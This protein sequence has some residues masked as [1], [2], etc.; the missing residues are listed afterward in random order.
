M[1]RP[2]KLKIQE[3]QAELKK[4]LGKQKTAQGKERV[5]AL[6]LL[7]CEHVTTVTDLAVYMG[8][9]RVTVQKW[10]ALYRRGG[11]T[12]LLEYKPPSGRTPSIPQWAVEALKK[13]LAQPEGFGSYHAVQQWLD[14]TL[15]VTASYAAVYRLV[16]GKLKAKLKV[17]KRQSPEQDPE[18]LHRFKTDLGSELSLLK[19]FV[20]ERSGQADVTIRFWCQDET[21]WCLTTIC[22]RLITA[23]GVKPVGPFQWQREGYWLYGLVEPLSGESFFYEFSHLDRVCF[24]KSLEMFSQSYPDDWHIIQMDRASAHTAKKLVVP[25]NVIL[26][27]QPS[28]SPELNPIERLWEHLKDTFPWQVFGSVE[29]LRQKVRE[30]LEG[31]T[32]DVVQSLTG[33][34]YLLDALSIAGFS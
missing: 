25:H 11:M 13:R 27:F 24:E 8:R 2:L 33:W 28:H 16:R 3:S 34:V 1:A 29:Q 20:Q 9:H 19:G 12:A 15:G 30:L 31:L 23:M 26:L 7:K 4:L 5:Q 21:R 32:Q 14:D 10:L 22:R 18:K 17:A 6:Y